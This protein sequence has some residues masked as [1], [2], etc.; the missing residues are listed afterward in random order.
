M[1]KTTIHSDYIP[2]NAITGVKIAENSITA[3]E[4][5]TNAITSLYVADDSVTA[6]KLAN[7]INTDIATGVAALP[8]AGGTMTGDL[9]VGATIASTGGTT[10]NR[11]MLLAHQN[12]TNQ[13]YVGRSENGAADT[14][15][16]ITFDYDN[17]KMQLDSDGDII[18]TPT[19]NVGIG[20][21][22]P[23][24]PLDVS[25]VI[26]SKASAALND[27]QIGRLN[28]TN[29]NSNASSNPIRASI[30]SGR[31]NSAWGGYLSLYTSTGTSAASEKVRIGETGKVGIGTTSPGTYQLAVNS[32]T[33][34]VSD[35]LAGVYI[36]GQRSGVVYNLVSNNTGNAANRGS[37]IQFR[38]AGFLSGAILHRTDGTAASGD[39][40]GYMTFHTSTDNSEDIAERLRIDSSG[41][42]GI[43]TNSPE[44][45][46]HVVEQNS[47]GGIK[48]S[49]ANAP[50]ITI[51]DDSDNAYSRIVAQN[52]G[53]L[54]ISADVANIGSGSFIA[55]RTAGDVERMRI[56]SSGNV[57]IGVTP[58]TD[59]HT[60]YD[61][62][63]I[64]ESSAF[65]ANA[66][67]DEIFMAQNARYTSGGWKYNSSGTATLFDMQSGNT[68]WR[69]AVSGSDNGTISWSDSMFI[70]TSGKVG[71]GTTSPT[72]DLDVSGPS[73][74]MVLPGTSGTTPKGFLRL[75]YNDRNWGG[76]ELLMGVINDSSTGY[77]GYLQAK[78]PTN[79]SVN[80]NFVINPQ[81]GNVGIGLTTP[82]ENLHVY[83][84]TGNVPAKFESG[85]AYSIIVFADSGSSGTVGI[86]A[87]SNDLIFYSGDAQR[88]R[89]SSGGVLAV[90]GAYNTTSSDA[91]NVRVLSNGNIVR[92]TSSRKYKNS[93]TDA[94]KGLTELNNL[95]PVT[96]KGNNDGETVFYGL[97]AE[98]VHDVGL[99]EF[100]EYNDD[101]EPDALRY[102]HMVSLCIKA[103][104]ELKT[105]L[106][107]TKAR[108]TEL[109][110]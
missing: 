68:R 48:V 4:I 105:E 3:R 57:G 2:D 19:S 62:I 42:V 21:T 12:N 79:Y 5:A 98:E 77:A 17:D 47:Y 6:D 45:K 83:S 89:L 88:M 65:F 35:A 106:D 73:S 7:S 13:S 23:T 110:G 99:T 70:N 34:G 33:A 97:I 43:G 20:T 50:G 8:K 27:A 39:A 58:K 95:R 52:N 78:A 63:Q 104:Q 67:A 28:F 15:N 74:S 66:A 11:G 86:G 96:Y 101:N 41:K 22:S 90:D 25:G 93:I 36:N 18:L 44:F 94:S 76:T 80:R 64:G 49:G 102:P 53:E 108:I 46:L 31:Q 14:G 59:W 85:D 38:H 81:G 60:G 109:E 72:V 56:D 9:K 100:V 30:L 10:N 29:T 16:R 54:R 92:S 40:P 75:G 69:R 91:A 26:T 87:Q 103:I 84:G 24:S 51:E 71:I 32:G 55:F 82:S 1:A 61:A 37:G 107:A